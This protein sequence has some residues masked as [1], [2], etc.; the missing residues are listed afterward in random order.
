MP[1]NAETIRYY[2]YN[3][4]PMFVG[5]RMYDSMHDYDGGIID[6]VSG[7]YGGHAGK[8]IYCFLLLQLIYFMFKKFYLLAMELKM[9]PTI[10]Y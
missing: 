6:E 3:S 7:N 2:L 4:G 1:N 9:E 10:G 5:F 8:F